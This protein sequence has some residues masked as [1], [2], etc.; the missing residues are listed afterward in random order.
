[1][2]MGRVM[3]GSILTNQSEVTL[4]DTVPIALLLDEY[5]IIAVPTDS[6]YQT[7]HDLLDEFKRDPERISWGGGSAG[8]TDHILVAMIAKAAGVD[9]KKI[10]YV[11]YSG[12]GEAAVSVMGGNVSAGVSGYGEWK[13]YVESGKLRY[14]AVSSGHRLGNDSTPA[15]TESGLNVSMSNWR[16]IVAPRGTEAATRAWL[17]EALTR[18]R[19]TTAWQDAV[20]KN[21]WT[22]TFLT[23]PE[24]DRFIERETAENAEM[25]A[26][27]GLAGADQAVAEYATVGPWAIPGL[28]GI[29]LLLSAVG[30]VGEAQARQRA[31]STNERPGGPRSASAIARSPNNRPLLQLIDWK[32]AGAVCAVLLA[33]LLLLNPVGYLVATAG[34]LLIITRL[35]GSRRTVRDVIFSVVTSVVVYTFFNFVLKVGLPSGLLG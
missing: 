8:G 15:I 13:P 19:R 28:I 10:N 31:A 26:S 33:Y 25:L 3:L 12:G 18:M 5:E 27:I 17:T 21:D 32:M 9:P 34:F 35:L 6:K 2:V 20:R 16:A 11:A 23:G 22:D 30:A 7:F 1:M 14:L 24:L 4:K 29:G